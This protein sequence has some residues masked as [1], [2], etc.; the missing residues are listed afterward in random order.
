M[1]L[2]VQN[3]NIQIDGFK[4]GPY[5]TNSYI[6]T[7]PRTKESVVVD[8][9][10]DAPT[11][12][13]QLKGTHP[14][15]ILITHN[16][17]DHLGSL[18]DLISELGIPVAAHPE[19]AKKL[20]SSPEILLADGGTLSFGNVNLSVLHTPGHTPGS[21]CFLTGEYLISGDTIFPGGPGRT[22]SPAKLKQII[23]SITSK[24]F[25]LPDNTQIFPGHGDSTIL[26]KEKEAFAVFSSRSHDPDL[27]GDVLWL[28]T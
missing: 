7:C 25:S 1:S 13:R 8:A 16:H 26:K 15:Y 5:E 6:L 12:I 3:E 28:S 2:F 27:C 14:R 17:M 19:D 11:V 23:E 9:P 20:P 4:L 10:A 21:V 24:I 22:G 18:S